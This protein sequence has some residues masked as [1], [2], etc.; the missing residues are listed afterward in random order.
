V[1]ASALRAVTLLTLHR[2]EIGT[3]IYPAVMD[4]L[5]RAVASGLTRPAGRPADRD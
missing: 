5:I 4:C 1:I 2:E 3:E